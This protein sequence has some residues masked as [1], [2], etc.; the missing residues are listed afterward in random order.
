MDLPSEPFLV[1]HLNVGLILT[2]V[3]PWFGPPALVMVNAH[4]ILRKLYC[5]DFVCASEQLAA[6]SKMLES[7]C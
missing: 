5:F 2:G 3:N 6:C 4:G 1:Y 7:G